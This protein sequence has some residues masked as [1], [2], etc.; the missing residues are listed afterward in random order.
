M[1]VFLTILA[2]VVLVLPLAQFL[3]SLQFAA[4]I[5]NLSRRLTATQLADSTSTRVPATM[6]AFALRNGGRVGGPS[7]VT[8]VQAAEMRLAIGQPFFRLDASQISGTRTPGFVWQAKGA[9]NGI[10]PLT[11][12]D[13]YVDGMGVLEVRI[14]GSIPIATSAGAET[15][16]GEAMRFLAELPWNPDA[17]LNAHALQWLVIDDRALLVSMDTAGGSAQVKLRLDA[18][19]DIVQISAEGR[20]RADHDP[21]RWVGRFARYAQVGA[22]RFPR[23]GEVAWDLPDGEFIYWRGD[24]LSIS[25]I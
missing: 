10:I 20:P 8:M 6:R 9:M 15:S 7:T 16:L 5:K 13:S 21:A 24:I 18:A 12:V 23:H 1:N 2:V 19:G 17:I 25:G 14:A 11:I 22:Y 4:K 3:L